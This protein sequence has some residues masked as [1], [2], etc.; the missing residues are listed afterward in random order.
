MPLRTLY[1]LPTG[2][3]LLAHVDV[4]SGTNLIENG[5]YE[6]DIAGSRPVLGSERLERDTSVARHGQASLRV[7]VPNTAGAG[8]AWVTR[9]GPRIACAP[10]Q[11][12]V[13][14]VDVY[15]PPAAAGKQV[16]ATLRWHAAAPAEAVLG[17][18]DGPPRV[19]VEGWQRLS[20]QAGPAPANT[21]SITPACA[22]VG[23]QG[24]FDFHVDVAHL[25]LGEGLILGSPIPT[26]HGPV[27]APDR[28][29]EVLR[30]NRE[31]A[32]WQAG[33]V[34]PWFDVTWYGADPTGAADSTNGINAA[35][36]DAAASGGW[37][38]VL[39]P[40]G[41]YA[42]T[43]LRLKSRVTLCGQGHKT[44]LVQIGPTDG[45]MI[46]LDAS[47]VEKVAIRDLRLVGNKEHQVRPNRGIFLGNVGADF[48]DF[49]TGDSVHTIQNVFIKDCK[50][51]GFAADSSVRDLHALRVHVSGCE[52]PGFDV[53]C[54]D[55]SF[56]ACTAGGCGQGF[57]VRSYN[58]HYVAC[59]AFGNVGSPGSPGDGFVIT[60]AGAK[61]SACEAQDNW[62]RG[63]VLS[64]ASD[65]VLTS[66]A[67]DTNGVKLVGD[68]SVAFRLADSHHCVV[69][70]AA[71][72]RRGQ[73]ATQEYGLEI[74][75]GSRDNVVLLTSR[76][77]G[78]AHLLGAAGETNW[79]VIN[80]R[81]RL[82]LVASGNLP[83]AGAD[84]DGTVLI[85]NGGRGSRG[86]VYY[87][88]GQR[89]RVGGTAF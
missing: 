13:F 69:V 78:T 70:G 61:F 44:T 51:A 9:A 21:A 24:R 64:D 33:T 35:I 55:S 50:G 27:T 10:G 58:T 36:A 5:D 28:T 2:Q 32:Q 39:C 45:D 89:F 74:T 65:C 82:P 14:S 47:K 48:V 67:A 17:T 38:V 52:G 56:V 54:T 22:G 16:R 34:T 79:I 84:Q 31:L 63:F 4:A 72:N 12:G 57:L 30:W 71:W 3:S 88:G 25:E 42:I 46:V 77:H 8:V 41:D 11:S 60:A 18:V 86:L 26:S 1:Q 49:D 66:V 87:A 20:V 68:D 62:G 29:G 83:R 40:A 59:K 81:P 53:V 76:D 6:L 19:L 73:A 80:G 43:Q 75:G 85:E 15:A 23:P 37:A 7:S